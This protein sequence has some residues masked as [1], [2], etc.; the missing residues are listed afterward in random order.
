MTSYGQHGGRW[1]KVLKIAFSKSMLFHF[2]FC[3]GSCYGGHY[4][5]YI[6]D[7]EGLSTWHQPVSRMIVIHLWSIKRH[8]ELCH[9]SGPVLLISFALSKVAMMYPFT[10]F[11]LYLRTNKYFYNNQKLKI[12]PLTIS[13]KSGKTYFKF[14]HFTYLVKLLIN[15]IDI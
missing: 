10:A 6:R 11:L 9:L 15:L 5:A 14:L 1:V 7:V 12:K 3:S 4:H 2:L 8:F 13:T